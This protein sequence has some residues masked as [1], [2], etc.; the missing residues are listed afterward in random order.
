[1]AFLNI[2]VTMIMI[3]I[4]RPVA[5]IYGF[6]PDTYELLVRTIKMLGIITTPKMFAYIFAVG[7]FRGGGDTIFCMIMEAVCNMLIQL[8]C[9][10]IA[11]TFLNFDLPMAMAMGELGDL[12]RIIVFVPRFRSKKWINIVK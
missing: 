10:Y 5:G 11:V 12:V 8:P 7:I 1:M 2:I 3:G 6:E 9:V 4:S